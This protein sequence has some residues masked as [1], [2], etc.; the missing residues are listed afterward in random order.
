M[1]THIVLE[2]YAS[3]H[4]INPKHYLLI[5][6]DIVLQLTVGEFDSLKAGSMFYLP[7]YPQ[8][9]A[10]YVEILGIQQMNESMNSM[11]TLMLMKTEIRSIGAQECNKQK[12][13]LKHLFVY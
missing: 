12:P 7:S 9:V 13:P 8:H 4:C 2:D 11:Y 10:Y 1:W 6:V 5:H 3:L